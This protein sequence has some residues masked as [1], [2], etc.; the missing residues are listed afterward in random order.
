MLEYFKISFVSTINIKSLY[1]Q[2]DSSDMR[3][4]SHI[5]PKSKNPFIPTTA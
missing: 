1:P 3:K 5:L 2:G 4:S